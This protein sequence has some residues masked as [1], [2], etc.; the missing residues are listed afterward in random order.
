M[1]KCRKLCVNGETTFAAKTNDK[2]SSLKKLL[3]LKM[4]YYRPLEVGHF[5]IATR[6]E[7]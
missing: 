1:N 2:D 7:N 3:N 4:V 6:V 5:V